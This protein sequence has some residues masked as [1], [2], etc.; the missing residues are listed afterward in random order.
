[1]SII[2]IF[3]VEDEAI[4]VQ[5]SSKSRVGPRQLTNNIENRLNFTP[6]FGAILSF[7]RH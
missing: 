1:M 2:S 3:I 4:I 5:Q 7:S 6:K